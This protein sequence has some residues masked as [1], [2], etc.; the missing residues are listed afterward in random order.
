[1]GVVKLLSPGKTLQ[2]RCLAM[3]ASQIRTLTL[4]LQ[5]KDVK[6]QQKAV[7]MAAAESDGV[8]VREN[9]AVWIEKWLLVIFEI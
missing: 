8:R 6:K 5:A 1:M 3:D 9:G 7:A 4:E 2:V